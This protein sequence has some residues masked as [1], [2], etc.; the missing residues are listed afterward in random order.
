MTEQ[1]G[2]SLFDEPATNCAV[3]G[4][5]D[6]FHD[7]HRCSY[8]DCLCGSSV[9]APYVRGSD[10]SRDA[11]WSVEG[12]LG[13]DAQ[14]VYEAIE[15]SSDGMTCDEVEESLEMRHQTASARIKG[16]RDVGRIIDSGR[17]RPTRSGRN[18]AVYERRLDG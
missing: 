16:L 5:A 14:R 1:L 4:H 9:T 8:P 12:R 6:Y 11:A 10:T 13:A 18:A 2:L 17:R 3:C 7:N 15:K